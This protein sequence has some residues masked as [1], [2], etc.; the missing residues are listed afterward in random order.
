MSKL[1]KPDVPADSLRIRS[2]CDP[3][4]RTILV[5]P[6]RKPA[7]TTL[8]VTR[9]CTWEST[10]RVRLLSEAGV[11][12]R[13]VDKSVCSIVS[14]CF[15]LRRSLRATTLKHPTRGNARLHERVDR[16][17]HGVTQARRGLL[18]SK[19]QCTGYANSQAGERVGPDAIPDCTGW[20]WT[21]A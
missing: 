15:R 3:T 1:N 18:R 10:R 17:D 7:R 5:W 21:A 19:D 4:C 9:R 20:E 16:N 6:G 8:H 11:G 13:I 14:E 2:C 12:S